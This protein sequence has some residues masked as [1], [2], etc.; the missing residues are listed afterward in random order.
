MIYGFC[1]W[2]PAFSCR[3]QEAEKAGRFERHS[4][5]VFEPNNH[6]GKQGATISRCFVAARNEVILHH[7]EKDSASSCR[8]ERAVPVGSQESR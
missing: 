3:F 5:G 2:L 7:W 4:A 1:E 8:N 6:L